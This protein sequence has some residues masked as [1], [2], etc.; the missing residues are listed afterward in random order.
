[1]AAKGP[2][3]HSPIQHRKQCSPVMLTA[4][5]EGRLPPGVGFPLQPCSL[6]SDGVSR[7]E[8]DDPSLPAR[9]HP[10]AL[11]LGHW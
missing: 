9:G 2:V 10:G 4:A 7:G 1:M 8:E 11:R 5:P 3:A 6:A